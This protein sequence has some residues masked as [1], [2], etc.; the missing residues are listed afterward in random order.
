MKLP[1]KKMK[2]AGASAR[3]MVKKVVK[4]VKRKAAKK[5]G[6]KPKGK[7]AGKGGAAEKHVVV[8]HGLAVNRF[9]MTGISS[10]LEKQG[11]TVHAISYPSRAKSFE[12]LVD[13]HVAPV[14]KAIPADKVDFVAHSMGGLL[15]R[16]Y[17]LK[18]G[19]QKI[20]RVVMLG[21]PNHGSAVADFM[22]DVPGFQWYFG[23]AGQTLGTNKKGIHAGLPPVNFECGV[24]AGE[25]HWFRVP[26]N[27]IVP[28]LQY[29]HD[30]VVS[31]ESTKVEGMKEHTVIFGDHSQMVWMPKVWKLVANFLKDGKFGV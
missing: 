30:G 14:I 23:E 26:T 7:P 8:L 6:P 2:T 10:S 17:A 19:T 11:Y 9:F 28:N 16:I 4:T 3:K 22:R 18:Y 21:T 25:N 15:V 31:V 13:E 27:L 20:R 12:T 29:P 24:I 1:I 5:A